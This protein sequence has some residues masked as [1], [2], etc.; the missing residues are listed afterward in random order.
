MEMLA[1]ETL[2]GEEQEVEKGSEQAAPAE[3]VVGRVMEVGSRVE[4]AAVVMGSRVKPAAVNIPVV[5]VTAMDRLEAAVAV[6]VVQNI[7]Q[8]EGFL[9]SK[10]LVE[11]KEMM[12]LVVFG[13][14][15]CEG[16]LR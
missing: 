1:F 10:L 6:V 15:G 12:E 3:E 8:V 5:V 11:E 14:K 4:Q 2:E 9:V 13:Q 16:T 7:A